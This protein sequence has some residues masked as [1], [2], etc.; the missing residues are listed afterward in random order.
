MK[1]KDFKESLYDA[2]DNEVD[3]MSYD[4]KND[5]CA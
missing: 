2:L 1:R 4:E 3:G 5:A